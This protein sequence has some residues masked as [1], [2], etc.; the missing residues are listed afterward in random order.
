MRIAII[1]LA[2]LI[3]PSFGVAGELPST[4]TQ[5]A[6][7]KKLKTGTAPLILDVR[8]PAEYQSGHVPQAVNIPHL[9]LPNRLSE[10]GD[11]KDQEVVVYC[12]RGPRAGFSES[13]LQNAGFNSVRHL[14]G[15][16]WAWRNAGLPTERP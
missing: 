12:E 9:Q 4:I 13:V 3:A 14:E 6:L 5:D 1:L 10:L 7:L 11:V 2:F 8:T 15:D 16:M